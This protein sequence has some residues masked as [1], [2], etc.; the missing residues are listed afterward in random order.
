MDEARSLCADAA[1][2]RS[3]PMVGTA[4]HVRRFLLLEHPGPWPF[5]ALEAEGLEPVVDDLVAATRA[6]AGRTFLIRRPG[7]QPD[8]DE[9]AWAVADV[10]NGRITWGTWRDPQ[11]LLAACDP[12]AADSAGWGSD[13]ALLVCA[14]GRHDTCCAVRGRPVAAALEREHGD[15]V[16]ECSHVGGDRFAANVVVVPDGTYYGGLDAD[17]ALAVV[18]E[19]LAGRVSPAFL[20]GSSALPPV[21]QAVAASA[22]ERWGPGGA[23]DV[24]GCHVEATS[25]TTWQVRL[26]AGGAL[27][28]VVTAAVRAVPAEAAVLTCR[29]PQATTAR[30][31]EVTDLARG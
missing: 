5:H 19:H 31:F 22:H 27:P 2:E 26:E 10:E 13:P 20:R 12:L 14:H 16:W 29:A 24:T 21:A 4:L 28:D 17:D 6:A 9:R 30:R 15:A 25:A 1:R 8:T 7:R 11:D 23:R 18:D 3:D